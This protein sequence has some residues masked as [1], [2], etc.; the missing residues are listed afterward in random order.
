M[1]NAQIIAGEMIL[2]GV[3]EEV[4][5]YAGWSRR[6]YQVQKGE[7]ARFK[8][9]IWKPAKVRKAA[10]VDQDADG[11]EKESKLIMVSASFFGKSQVALAVGE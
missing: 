5:T 4:D 6:G 2:H 9:R 8:T 3:M 7:K 11:D 10:T 1:T